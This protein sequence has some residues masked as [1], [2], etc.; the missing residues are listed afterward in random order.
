M[1]R[2]PPN[3]DGYRTESIKIISGFPRRWDLNVVAIWGTIDDVTV[4][5]AGFGV[6]FVDPTDPIDRPMFVLDEH[7]LRRAIVALAKAWLCIKL[8]K[9]PDD[10]PPAWLLNGLV[11]DEDFERMAQA[12]GR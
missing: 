9:R 5:F 4:D 11:P 7:D 8:Q 3:G 10:L 1:E 2:I 6:E 12:E